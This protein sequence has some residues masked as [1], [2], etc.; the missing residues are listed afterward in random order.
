M[1]EESEIHDAD[2]TV[3]DM[4]DPAA[5]EPETS[6]KPSA[7]SETDVLKDRL[8]RL[9]A[10]FDN[11][12]KRS[13]R[14]RSEWQAFAN[15]QLIKDILPVVDHFELGL[16]NAGK[17]NTPAAVLD[18][19]KL[20]YEQLMGFLK[21][22]GVAVL[23]ATPGTKFDPHLHEAISHLPS[24][25]QPADVIIAETRRGYKLGDKM[26]RPLQVVVSSGPVANEKTG[27]N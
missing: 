12:R 8:L 14:E 20:V 11:F 22:Q 18:G 15:E 19:L 6:A 7:P 4:P 24:E 17:N 16:A 1:N 21:K 26:I 13:A 27:G 2:E 3:V 10:D 25:D 9:Q 5:A 23:S